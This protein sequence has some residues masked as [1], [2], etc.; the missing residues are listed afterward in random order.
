MRDSFT[1]KN[2]NKDDNKEN[3][4]RFSS[5]PFDA[6]LF[7]LNFVPISEWY[8]LSQVNTSWLENTLR[9]GEEFR[10]VDL[11]N[12]T[13]SEDRQYDDLISQTLRLFPLAE[14]L[15]INQSAANAL[16]FKNDDMKRCQLCHLNTITI[17][18]VVWPPSAMYFRLPLTVK[19]LN[20]VACSF[21]LAWKISNLTH[22]QKI[23]FQFCSFAYSEHI[24]LLPKRRAP[25]IQTSFEN[26]M[27]G[28]E[29]VPPCKAD[30]IRPTAACLLRTAPSLPLTT[31]LSVFDRSVPGMVCFEGTDDEMIPLMTW[32]FEEERCPVRWYYI[33][34]LLAQPALNTRLSHLLDIVDRRHITS[35]ITDHMTLLFSIAMEHGNWEMIE[36]FCLRYHIDINLS[37]SSS[38][39]PR[40]TD[41]SPS[42]TPL[43]LQYNNR[44][45]SVRLQSLYDTF[46]NID[47]GCQDS[48][49]VVHKIIQEDR[50][51]LK[52]LHTFHGDRVNFKPA[53]DLQRN[54]RRYNRNTLPS[55]AILHIMEFC[56]VTLR[57]LFR[58]LCHIL[59]EMQQPCFH[60]WQ[61]VLSMDGSDHILTSERTEDGGLVF[62]E[63]VRFPELRE[64][65]D[66]LLDGNGTLRSMVFHPSESPLERII[67]SDNIN[68]GL[69]HWTFHY[70]PESFDADH[71]PN[72]RGNNVLHRV[73]RSESHAVF[74]ALGH[75]PSISPGQY[76]RWLYEYNHDGDAPLHG[77][78]AR[79]GR[80][81]LGKG[82]FD[83]MDH[84][85][86]LDAQGR[87]CL[88]RLTMNGSEPSAIIN[89]LRTTSDLPHLWQDPFHQGLAALFR[90]PA[91]LHGIGDR[92]SAILPVSRLST[93]TIA[94]KHLIHIAAE[95]STDSIHSL[96][97]LAPHPIPYR[98]RTADPYRR[99]AMHLAAE[100]DVYA[101]VL[102]SVFGRDVFESRD[103]DDRTP[104]DVGTANYQLFL[105][106]EV[107]EGTMIPGWVWDRV[108]G[109][110]NL[111]ECVDDEHLREH[112]WE[113][114][115]RCLYARRWDCLKYKYNGAHLFYNSKI[116]NP[117][118]PINPNN[119]NNGTHEMKEKE[120]QE[121]HYKPET[122]LTMLQ[123]AMLFG[124]DPQVIRTFVEGVL[125]MIRNDVS[126]G[127]GTE[128]RDYV[129]GT[130]L[131]KEE[132]DT[133]C[134]M[135]RLLVFNGDRH[136][137]HY[138]HHT[139]PSKPNKEWHIMMKYM[140]EIGLDFESLR[141]SDGTA[142]TLL[143]DAVRSGKAGR[144]LSL[145]VEAG[146]SPDAMD[147]AGNTTMDLLRDGNLYEGLSWV[148][149]AA[150][151]CR[152]RKKTRRIHTAIKGGSTLQSRK[153]GSPGRDADPG[154]NCRKRRRYSQRRSSNQGKKNKP[155]RYS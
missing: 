53:A 122:S 31:V 15:V 11:T 48:I 113:L 78:Q 80:E 126:N 58:Q 111:V 117:N 116:N 147:G 33:T 70:A 76:S 61:H 57:D 138:N 125:H 100:H 84:L 110:D 50:D 132:R 114:L 40:N 154:R 82:G 146:I 150:H 103:A 124:N 106:L 93:I 128:A 133:W 141:S 18:D 20:F 108:T 74:L 139:L 52:F 59:L 36:V 92:L 3:N 87:S 155:F 119:P 91:I 34:D 148:M 90:Q 65:L 121:H 35:M 137:Y 68:E 44:L 16:F 136:C 37:S 144:T 47:L 71:D 79:V 94:G 55:S 75:A 96:Q 17:V 19:N 14:H 95:S 23:E 56:H 6:Y 109:E 72:G 60:L 25:H 97:E 101:P 152:R 27:V 28:F 115:L 83:S 88:V 102:V 5:L 42:E 29:D 143:H 43:W 24:H 107:E 46:P 2:H 10:R 45:D 54:L 135:F 39:H 32:W 104:F 4:N 8:I 69:L 67:E 134:W 73:A 131:A 142:S 130:L 26:S 51:S 105:I 81:L 85:G 153:R 120:E 98:F 129:E 7:I 86:L 149:E 38:D 127:N 145:L 41:L 9:I 140:W 66:E 22:V 21:R 62:W 112:I 123:I 151:R 118:N 49:I 30:L 77:L 12:Q 63:L 13:L 99:T 64:C 89:A 1:Q